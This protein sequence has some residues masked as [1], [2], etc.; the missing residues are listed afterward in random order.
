[1]RAG[2]PQ[3][4]HRALCSGAPRCRSCCLLCVQCDGS[5][6]RSVLARWPATTA[7]PQNPPLLRFPHLGFVPV[8]FATRW[9]T[10]ASLSLTARSFTY[11][12]PATHSSPS[13]PPS[14]TMPHQNTYGI[15]PS[16]H[17]TACHRPCHGPCH[18][19]CPWARRP[20]PRA[21][22]TSHHHITSRRITA[23]PGAYHHP[24]IFQMGMPSPAHRNSDR[25]PL[26][27]PILNTWGCRGVTQ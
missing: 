19:A 6:H 10:T 23:H 4:T 8:S 17:P 20:A 1:M 14:N 7:L 16:P 13:C 3:P 2:A 21:R 15:P 27:A 9:H 25:K 26:R 18:G 22:T 5:G 24:S 12:T 11:T